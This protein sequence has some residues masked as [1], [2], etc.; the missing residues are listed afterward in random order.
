MDT[1]LRPV[2]DDLAAAFDTHRAALAEF[3]AIPSVSTDPAHAGDVRRAAEWVAGRL[4]A[5]GPLRVE[6]AETGGHPAVLAAWDGAE[7]APTVLVYGHMD[8]QPPDPLDA[9]ASP[10]FELTERDGRWYARGVSDDKASML[11]PILVTE[12]FF[13][14]GAPPVNLRLV[15][16]AEEEVGSPHLPDLVRRR[17]E[18]LACDVV[19]SADGGMW[20][21]DLPSLTTRARGMCGLELGVRGAAKDLHSGRHGGAIANPLHALADL[22]AGLHDDAGRVAVAGFYDDVEPPTPERL[23]ELEALPFD[24]AD[25]LRETG[26]PA[27]FGEPGYGTLAR[28]WLRPT[29]EVNGLGGGYQGPGSKT[30]LPHRA[31]AKL[32]CRLVPDQRPED[33]LGAVEA[34]LR[35]SRPPGV[36]LEV[37]RSEMGAGAYRLPGDHPALAAAEAVLEETFGRPPVRV[38]MGGSVPIVATFREAL[39]ADTLFFSFSTADEDIHAPN[40]FYRPE[41]FR[42]GLAAWARLWARLA[43][44][45]ASGHVGRRA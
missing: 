20:R 34:H 23:A 36:T 9:W 30:V 4:R 41:R 25:Y 28:R 33:V 40:E 37:R 29:L 18:E 21:A 1:A 31:F 3:V 26:A 43:E 17:A 8:V 15:F 45:G 35:R 5:A 11:I 2:L 32:T 13:R 24:D 19:L 6:V 10:P 7:G 38:G 44:P 22:L 42:A 12:A 39:G 14:H 16:E 27:T